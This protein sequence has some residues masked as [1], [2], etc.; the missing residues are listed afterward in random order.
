[1]VPVHQGV[2]EAH[3]KTFG[4]DGFDVFLHQVAAGTLLGRAVIGQLGVEVA[5]A[6][7]VL[8]GHHHVFLPGDFGQLGPIARGVGFGL[9]E[10]G[11]LFV[12]R[13]RNAFLFH[14]PFVAAEGAVQAPVDEHAEAGFMPPL[15][16][17]LASGIARGGRR[18]CAGGWAGNCGGRSGGHQL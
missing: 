18:G 2:V 11:L 15:H 6:F 9:E 7:M 4:A 14:R 3:A 10:L 1:M 5:E 16:A 8:G 17:G 12:F 13:H